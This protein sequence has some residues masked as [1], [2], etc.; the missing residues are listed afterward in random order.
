MEFINFA[1]VYDELRWSAPP[2]RLRVLDLSICCLETFF[3][4][5]LFESCEKVTDYSHS[6]FSIVP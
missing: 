4:V 6:C 2:R 5:K 3:V 1:L